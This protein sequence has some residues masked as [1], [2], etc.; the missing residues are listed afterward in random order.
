MMLRAL[1]LAV[2]LAPAARADCE[3]CKKKHVKEIKSCG[4]FWTPSKYVG[5]FAKREAPAPTPR[6]TPAPVQPC[7]DS[8]T[9]CWYNTYY[10]YNC[11]TYDDYGRDC[12][13][14]DSNSYECGWYDW[15]YFKASAQCCACGG[16]TSWRRLG[17]A[18][19]EA[20]DRRFLT[21]LSLIHI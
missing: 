4:A 2:A 18:E 20:E 3:V 5:E 16:G 12:S 19:D 8:T 11:Y 1:V 7:S 13:Y 14:Y 17:E 21:H 9:G 6:P 10:G 15:D